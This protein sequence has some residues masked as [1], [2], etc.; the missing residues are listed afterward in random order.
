MFMKGVFSPDGRFIASGSED[1]NIY[2]WEKSQLQFGF[3]NKRDKINY[4]QY[5][6]VII[7]WIKVFKSV[8]F[9]NL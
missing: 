7:L 3:K 6:K 4:F 5:V 8:F 2:S 1:G 9:F